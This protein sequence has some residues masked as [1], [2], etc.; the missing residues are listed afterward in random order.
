MS[1]YECTSFKFKLISLDNM[2]MKE[3]SQE[4]QCKVEKCEWKFRHKKQQQIN[5]LG[6]QITRLT[7][8]TP[9]LV[10]T[11]IKKLS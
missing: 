8:T 5:N 9:G 3:E 6:R 2:S 1:N 10:V 4:I 11:K 7:S